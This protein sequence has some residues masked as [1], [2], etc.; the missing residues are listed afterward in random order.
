MLALALTGAAHALPS[1]VILSNELPP[2][3]DQGTSA[4]EDMQCQWWAASYYM[5]THY[6]KHF[7]HPEWDL[8]N[9]QHQFSPTFLLNAPPSL[10]PMDKLHVAGCVDLVEV[11]YNANH[12]PALTSTQI[13]AAK[14]YRIT[15][16][17]TIWYYDG[18]ATNP[19]FWTQDAAIL[20][21]KTYLASGHVLD[22]GINASHK[23]FPDRYGTNATFYFDPTYTTG[24]V[25]GVGHQVA[26]CGYD[27]NINP[28][29]AGPDHQGGF[30][31][32]NEAGTNWNGA[33]HGF[34]WMSYAYVKQY[35]GD[36]HAITGI[37]SDLPLITGGDKNAGKVGD[38]V[39]ITG[40]SFGGERRA[41]RVT[42]NGVTATNVT[43]D[44][45][46]IT[47]LVPF[48]ATS[49]PLVVHNWEGTPSNGIEFQVVPEP[50]A[51]TLLGAGLLGLL[52]RR[53]APDACR[54]VAGAN[55]L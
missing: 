44:N 17:D 30:L 23:D 43:F 21:A 37:V 49:G 29:G 50:A 45:N 47:T 19:P 25:L 53:P 33:M 35:V 26:F 10:P 46:L 39:T 13:E 24:E 42:F 27:D 41:T 8:T 16:C 34:L 55:M 32:V 40:D 36:C 5:L 54:Q 22:V 20:T 52:R 2:I 3:G 38:L 28:T 51:L 14:P 31:M 1:S 9:P 18:N 15:G 7:E 11:P 12:P 48:G 6:V 4:T